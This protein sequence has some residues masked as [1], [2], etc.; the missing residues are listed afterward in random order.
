M[1]GKGIKHE[2]RRGKN[3]NERR[4]M[5]AAP[6]FATTL[7]LR[8]RPRLRCRTEKRV[9]PKVSSLIVTEGEFNA[10]AVCQAMGRPAASLPNGCR[11]PPAKVLAC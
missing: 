1:I 7:R 6:L 11:S 8:R 4:N 2:S 9:C 10:M 5:L 3:A